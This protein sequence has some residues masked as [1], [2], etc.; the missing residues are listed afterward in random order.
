[1]PTFGD[2]L[3]ELN[4]LKE[5]HNGTIPGAEIPD[6]L[7]RDMTMATFIVMMFGMGLATRNG[8]LYTL[9]CHYLH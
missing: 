8:L 2:Y 9:S 5:N 1:M 7:I 4:K 3:K 6:K